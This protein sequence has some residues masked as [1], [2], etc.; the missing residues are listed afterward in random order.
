MSEAKQKQQYTIDAAGKAFGRVASEAANALRGKH[1]SDYK[2]NELPGVS[3]VIQNASEVSIHDRTLRNK[4]YVRYS[5]YPGGKK[6][7]PINSVIEKRGRGELLR[8]A[9]YAML[10]T[11]RLRERLMENLTIKERT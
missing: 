2:P 5:G 9:T 3:V 4:T 1:L 8:R 6:E 10:P 11:N 7:E